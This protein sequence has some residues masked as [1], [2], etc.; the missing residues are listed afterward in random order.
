ML[1]SGEYMQIGQISELSGYSQRMIRYLEDQ[2]LIIPKRLDSNLRQFKDSDLTRILKVKRLKELGFTYAEIKELIDKDESVLAHK[3]SELL[4]RHHA[5]AS[6]LIEKIKQLETICYGFVKTKSIPDKIMTL[7]H[8]ERVAYRIK[9]LDLVC[10]NLKKDFSE[11]NSEII[12][13]KFG[14]FFNENRTEYSSADIIEI[15][16]GS[17]QMAVLK[18]AD[19]LSS[20]EKAWAEVSLAFN[21]NGVG[22]FGF[23]ELNEFFG[24]YEIVIE[25]KVASKDG[26]VIFHALLPYQAIF[27]ASGQANLA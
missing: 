25:H 17:S 7:S 21:G 24:N 27:I 5:E 3:G 22:Q 12:F 15:F 11:I 4:K 20:Y 10:E 6:D 19:F 16:R 23:N 14:E 1:F 13:W 2:G 18:G 8:P 9:K 26:T